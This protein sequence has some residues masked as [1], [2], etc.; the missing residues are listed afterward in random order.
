VKGVADVRGRACYVLEVA[1]EN[2]DP[3]IFWVDRTRLDILQSEFHSE[4]GAF[5]ATYSDFRKIQGNLSL[6][7]RVE[8]YQNREL[9]LVTTIQSVQVNS[10]L[11]DQYFNADQI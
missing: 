7:H 4:Q 6:P 9:L 11:E 10:G 2:N 5:Q 8:I 1:D 3:M